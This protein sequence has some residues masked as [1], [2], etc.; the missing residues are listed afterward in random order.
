MSTHVSLSKAE[1]VE[2]YWYPQSRRE[3]WLADVIVHVVG[4]VLALIGAM[5]GVTA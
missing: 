4:I 3:E 5:G 1:A 2:V